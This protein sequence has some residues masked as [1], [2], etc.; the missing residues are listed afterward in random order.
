MRR[1]LLTLNSTTTT[2]RSIKRRKDEIKDAEQA[3]KD[4]SGNKEQSDSESTE[5]LRAVKELRKNVADE[6]GHGLDSQDAEGFLK[7][8]IEK[9]KDFD[10]L[11]V[12][13]ERKKA[14]MT[15]ETMQGVVDAMR[16]TCTLSV[17][18]SLQK[19]ETKNPKPGPGK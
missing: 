6:A 10:A 17:D 13:D 18:V 5:K 9:Q 2:L 7:F 14:T 4:K 19:P 15:A 1:I 8:I 3:K 12:A 11:D 16:I